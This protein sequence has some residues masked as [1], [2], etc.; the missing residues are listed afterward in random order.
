VDVHA[1]AV[2]GALDLDAGDAGAL[3]AL[4]HELADGHVFLDVVA[5]ALTLLGGVGEPAA[6]VLRGDAQAKAV[7]VDLLTH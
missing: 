5:V 2:A 1:D 4:G 3:H 7:R 6:L